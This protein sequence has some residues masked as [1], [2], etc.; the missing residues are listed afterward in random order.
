[1]EGHI[2]VFDQDAIPGGR[3]T[4]GLDC[5]IMEGDFCINS[6][7]VKVCMAQPNASLAMITAPTSCEKMLI[8]F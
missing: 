3:R 2:N 4:D 6:R 8:D 5:V 1:M 7:D